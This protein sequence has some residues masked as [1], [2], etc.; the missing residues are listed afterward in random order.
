[1][2]R[3]VFRAYRKDVDS[4]WRMCGRSFQVVGAVKETD[5]WPKALVE[6]CD[7]VRENDVGET[8]SISIK[9]ICSVLNVYIYHFSIASDCNT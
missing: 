6:T 1:M 5:L 4:E 3:W 2:K 7:T 9:V 8:G